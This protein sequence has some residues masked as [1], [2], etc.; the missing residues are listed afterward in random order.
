MNQKKVS[1]AE[2]GK[3]EEKEISWEDIRAEQSD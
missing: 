3:R 2:G 1:E